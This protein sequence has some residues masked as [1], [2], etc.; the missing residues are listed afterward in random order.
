[1]LVKLLYPENAPSSMLLTP[2]KIVMLVILPYF[3]NAP[4]LIFVTHPAIIRF[5]NFGQS[6]NAESATSLIILFIVML[7]KLLHP[8][9]A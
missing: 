3:P 4:S 7:S 6:V 9:N 1:M 5:F 2:F 8:L